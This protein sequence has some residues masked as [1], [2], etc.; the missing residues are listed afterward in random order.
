MLFFNGENCV[1]YYIM[2]FSVNTGDSM[3]KLLNNEDN[4]GLLSDNMYV[5]FF[6]VYLNKTQH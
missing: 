6:V 1:F 3:E 5:S 4:V 2:V